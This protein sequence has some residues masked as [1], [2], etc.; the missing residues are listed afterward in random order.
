MEGELDAPFDLIGYMTSKVGRTLGDELS[1][2]EIRDPYFI[3]ASLLTGGVT[4][5][6]FWFTD[7]HIKKLLPKKW[8]Q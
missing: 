8:P 1:Y 5:R 7:Y 2:P 4:N 6:G 3:M